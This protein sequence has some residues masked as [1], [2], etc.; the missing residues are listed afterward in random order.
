MQNLSV[1][2]KCARLCRLYHHLHHQKHRMYHQCQE[3]V[4][5]KRNGDLN[6]DTTK[7]LNEML[8]N[9]KWLEQV[10][11]RRYFHHAR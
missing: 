4:E 10:R 2:S 11:R 3:V 5:A 1:C 6:A 9:E 8:A 7:I